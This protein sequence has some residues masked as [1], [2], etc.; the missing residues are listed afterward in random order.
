MCV[1]VNFKENESVCV[2]EIW[3]VNV[4]VGVRDMESECVC[5]REIWRVNACV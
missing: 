2:R 1:C 3:R 5:V 4:G